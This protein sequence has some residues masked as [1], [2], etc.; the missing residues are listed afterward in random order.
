MNRTTTLVLFAALTLPSAL[1]A[2]QPAP[3][4]P[5][6][7][8]FQALA[9]AG[10]VIEFTHDTNFDAIALSD[11]GEAAFVIHWRDG[12]DEHSAVLTSRHGIAS[13]RTVIDGKTVVRV[14]GPS[15]SI[16]SAGQVAFEALYTD[17]TTPDAPHTG[18]FLEKHFAFDLGRAAAPGDFTLSDGGIVL[19]REGLRY[20]PLPPAQPPASSAP[21]QPAANASPTAPTI[22]NPFHLSPKIIAKINKL[23]PVTFDPNQSQPQSRPPQAPPQPPAPPPPPQLVATPPPPAVQ[24]RPSSACPLPAFP[25]PAEWQMGADPGGPIVGHAFEAASPGRVYDSPV[26]GSLKSPIRSVQY[27]A[28]C[29]PILI[30]LADAAARGRFE[31]WTP[32]GLLTF[33]QPDGSWDFPG[34][35]E[36]VASGAFARTDT[37]IRINKRGQVLVPVNLARGSALLLG[38]PAGGPN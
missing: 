28:D 38:T 8:R 25:M 22:H 17:A 32:S 15:L 21:A 13:D 34:F 19:S 16:N 31:L 26:Y 20:P 12:N 36:K 11:A 24:T 3:L 2:Q 30:A 10:S 33:E 9:G 18:V 1:K 29:R 5:S 7:Y 6:A 14:T 27:A 37:S 4:P 35:A 23:S